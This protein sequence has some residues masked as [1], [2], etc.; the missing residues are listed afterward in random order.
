MGIS[1]S[2]KTPYLLDI[3]T[4]AAN[5]DD[6]PE[7]FLNIDQVGHVYIVQHKSKVSM[8]KCAHFSI[9]IDIAGESTPGERLAGLHIHIGVPNLTTIK[10]RL[11][12]N[13][14]YDNWNDFDDVRF[15]G[16]LNSNDITAYRTPIFYALI[17]KQSIEK[18]Y[19]ELVKSND[20]K[21][22]WSS[23]LNCQ[24]FAYKII[25][26][27]GFNWPPDYHVAG[28]VPPCIVDTYIKAKQVTAITTK[29]IQ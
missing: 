5:L 23:V 20:R 27:L 6:C 18:W 28:D 24:Q 21:L 29:S 25:N 19:T 4:M 15:I 1:N 7:D 2:Q 26:N 8:V 16:Q 12:Y 9:Y 22:T 11:I 10:T 3:H 14:E 17:L 13:Y